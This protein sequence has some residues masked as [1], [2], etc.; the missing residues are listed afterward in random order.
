MNSSRSIRMLSLCLLMVSAFVSG[1][2]A[3]PALPPTTAE[4]S[5]E[6][7]VIILGFVGGF[8]RYNDRVHYEVQLAAHL[9]KEYP[10]GT[11]VEI[12]ENH[13]GENAHRRILSLLDSNRDGTLTPEEKRG[14]RIILYGHSWGASEIVTLARRLQKDGIPVLLTVQV[15]SVAKV[16]ENDEVI[17]A[18]V[19]QAANFYQADGFLHGEPE[20]R[21]ADNSHTRIVGNFRFSYGA[22]P[23]NCA[24]YPWYARV[25][26]RAH[27]QIECDSK[28]WD[29]VESLIHATLPASAKAA[30]IQ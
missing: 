30:S 17:P 20:I 8:V 5:A 27:T 6:P 12:F 18:N 29:Q 21:A 7:P 23:Y 2:Y 11:I 28:V 24:D 1:S 14:A 3:R 15:D 16:G 13:S 25:F 9:R 26:M 19:A 10:T 4:G 22:S